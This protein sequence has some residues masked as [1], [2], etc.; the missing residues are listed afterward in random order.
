MN[1]SIVAAI[2]D[3]FL[4]VIMLPEHSLNCSALQLLS[5]LFVSVS[6]C[7]CV[8]SVCLYLSLSLCVHIKGGITG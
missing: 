2:L 3:V 6:V 4:R 7:L 8:G 1:S 5:L